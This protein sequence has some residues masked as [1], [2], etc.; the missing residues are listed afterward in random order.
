M[1]AGGRN[2]FL[3]RWSGQVIIASH[4]L[5]VDG[6]AVTFG[7]AMRGLGGAASRPVPSSLYQ[8]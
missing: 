8:M 4:T 7:T 1:R 2:D 3:A 5:I 6:S